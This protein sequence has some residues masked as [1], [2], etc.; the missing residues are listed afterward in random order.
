MSQFLSCFPPDDCVALLRRARAA[1]GEDGVVWILETCPDRQRFGVGRY[2]LRAISLYFAGL[3]TGNSRM[4]ES[5]SVI[6]FAEAA[7]LRVERVHDGLG[8]GSSLFECRP[9]SASGQG[10]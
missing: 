3:A 9:S 8:T 2:C 4:Y 7:G 10:T 5:A 1:L 6:G